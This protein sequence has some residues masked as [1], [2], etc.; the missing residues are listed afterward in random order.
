MTLMPIKYK[1]QPP[2]LESRL[3]CTVLEGI[4]THYSKITLHL[5]YTSGSTGA[6]KGV[7]VEHQT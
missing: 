1:N 6:P 4:A 7:L 5:I 3:M 2:R